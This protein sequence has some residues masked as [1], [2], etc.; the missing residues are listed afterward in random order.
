MWRKSTLAALFLFCTMFFALS[1]TAA[2]EEVGGVWKA[3]EIWGET[4]AKWSYNTETKTLTISGTG[5]HHVV[6]VPW[7]Q[8]EDDIEVLIVNGNIRPYCWPKKQMIANLPNGFQWNYDVA[9]NAVTISGKG[10][11]PEIQYVTNYLENE[12]DKMII[13]DED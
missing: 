7:E 9:S 12:P 2:A 4:D 3:D 6:P 11:F 10:E 5:G 13:E 8:F 1:M